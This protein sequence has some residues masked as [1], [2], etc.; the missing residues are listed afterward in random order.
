SLTDQLP[1][2]PVIWTLRAER[3][4]A[5]IRAYIGAVNPL[6]AHRLALRLVATAADLAEMPE[7]FRA[8]GP[9]RE[10]VIVRPYIIRYRITQEAIVILRVRHGARRG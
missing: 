10:L 8:A 5:A 4:L 1:S 2:R 7:R 3:E 9:D 6:A